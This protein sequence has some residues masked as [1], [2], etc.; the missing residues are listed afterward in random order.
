L[1]I[2]TDLGGEFLVLAREG[3][4][5]KPER[6]AL[7]QPLPALR[8]TEKPAEPDLPIA[9]PGSPPVRCA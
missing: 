9:A 2:A 1:H 5:A 7:L 4:A 8:Q 6:T 3:R